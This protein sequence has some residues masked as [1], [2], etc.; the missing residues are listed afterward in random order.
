MGNTPRK[1]R[2]E[3]QAK[4]VTKKKAPKKKNDKK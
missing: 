4:I 1:R 2:L 3:R